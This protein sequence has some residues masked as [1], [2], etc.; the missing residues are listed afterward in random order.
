MIEQKQF[1]DGF[2]RSMELLKGRSLRAVVL[3]LVMNFGLAAGLVLMY[4]VIVVVSAVI[5]TLFVDSYAAMAV[6][7]AVCTKL[8][9]VV[10]FIGGILAPLVD[11]G[12]SDR[13]ILP[14]RHEKRACSALGFYHA[15]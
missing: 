5:V 1:R 11:F 4:V 13:D 2:R 3:L 14:V 7:A 12:G 10:L 8:E 9:V 15:L 6:L